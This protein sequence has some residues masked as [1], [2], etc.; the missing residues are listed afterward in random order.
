M[1]REIIENTYKRIRKRKK[2]QSI[3]YLQGLI[4]SDEKKSL[5]EKKFKN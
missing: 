2:M 5:E 1:Q 3:A 4:Q